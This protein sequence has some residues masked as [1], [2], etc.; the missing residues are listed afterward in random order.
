[1]PRAS[2]RSSRGR[3][4]ELLHRLV[5]QLGG[6]VGV[7]RR[8]CRAPAAGSSSA[9]P[10]AAGR[11]RGGRAR[12]GA[13]PRSRPRRSACGRRAAPRPWP[14]SSAFSCSF[15]AVSAV[16]ISSARPIRER[17]RPI[18]KA[19]GR[20]AKTTI[21]ATKAT[22][23]RL[24]GTPVWPRTSCSEQDQEGE[25]AGGDDRGEDAPL[26]RRAAPPAAEDDRRPSTRSRRVATA[27]WTAL[28]ASA[29]PSWPAIRIGFSG[30]SAQSVCL[31]G[32]MKSTQASCRT[33]VRR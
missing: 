13:A 31:A 33:V 20:Q 26:R 22:S 30:Q 4:A 28:I 9:P 12:P 21:A 8:S 5:E 6:A 15:S 16:R 11:R 24:A 10:A 17:S 32:S 3:L 29:I 1:M 7:G 25:P 27:T 18:R 19:K 23:S 14:R 2:S